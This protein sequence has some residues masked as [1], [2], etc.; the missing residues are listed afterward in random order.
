MV[1]EKDINC[2]EKRCKMSH[3]PLGHTLIIANPAAHSG[4]GAAGAEFARHFLNSYSSATDGYEIKL[5]SAM[6]DARIMAAEAANFDTVV[7]L[8]GDGVI[9]EV[10]NGLMML[11]LE[12][13]P[14]LAVIPM[15]SGNDYARTLGMKINDPE[16]AFAQLV[17]G[18]KQ[19]FEIG[20]VNDVFFMQTMS[21]G[22]DAAIAIDTTNR[23]ANNTS[24]EGE[25]LFLTSGLKI[26]AAGSKGYPCTVS[27]DDEK[28][29]ELQSLIMAF[30]IGPTYGGGFTICP[31]ALPNDGLLT[32]CYN[33]KVPSIPRLL[34]LFGLARSGKHVNSKIITE[35]HISG[36]IV[37]FHK[38]VPAQVDGEELPFTEQF[39]IGIVPNALSV[40][41]PS[42]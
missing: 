21:F 37:T 34:T 9:H 39:V 13:R 6:G 4:K 33:T 2:T 23:R 35:R 19:K 22:L 42:L 8:G 17:R 18:Q 10:V 28:D 36:A 16:A 15:G 25:A 24:A 29:V 32:V 7:A 11:P 41:V 14:S 38:K 12:N 30:Q 1:K 27:F 20:K 31:N 5:T 40:I 3:S 26:M